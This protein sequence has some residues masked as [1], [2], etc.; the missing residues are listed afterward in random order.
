MAGL[1]A[2]GAYG[3]SS[4]LIEI[5]CDV[6]GYA[7]ALFFV[8]ASFWYLLRFLRHEVGALLAFSVIV[9]LGVLTEY[10]VVFYLAACVAVLLAQRKWGAVAAA[11]ILPC[12]T[13]AWLY[14]VHLRIQP[15]TENNVLD[16][17]WNGRGS[18]WAFVWSG[19]RS[20]FGYLMPFGLDTSHANVLA[21]VML[22]V[23]V[24]GVALRSAPA[25]ILALLLLELAILGITRR[26]PFGGYAR[27][28]SV[29]FPFVFLTMF[30]VVDLVVASV[31]FRAL[32]AAVVALVTA[33]VA[34][35]FVY[36]WR[37]VPKISKELFTETYA[38]FARVSKSQAVYVDQFSLIAYYIHVHSWEWTIERRL[39]CPERVDVYQTVSPAGEKRLVVRNLDEWNFDLTRPDTYN[40]LA[41]AMQQSHL[42]SIDLFYY[43]QGGETMSRDIASEKIAIQRLSGQAGLDM[44]EGM[45]NNAEALMTFTLRGD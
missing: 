38:D 28:Q 15:S 5:F 35:S 13:M 29:L 27:Q 41:N 14:F 36:D 19:I 42:S 21:L 6:R 43:R 25:Q 33:V 7:L 16:F 24:A 32:R 18:V 1:G 11:C 10:Y 12:L 4:T 26:Y 37:H 8:I 9:S 2:A 31:T 45:Y 40:V 39:R 20:D 17:Y 22:G 23:L 44:D 30:G 34:A 3:I